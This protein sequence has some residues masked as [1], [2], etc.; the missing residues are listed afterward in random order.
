MR[1]VLACAGLA[2]SCG[3]RDT[4]S[5]HPPEVVVPAAV[6]TLGARADAPCTHAP[7]PPRTVALGALAVDA[8][9][10]TQASWAALSA[11]P[12][13]PS[14][15]PR[16]PTCPVDILT[17]AEARQYCAE[18]ARA[19]GHAPCEATADCGGWRLPTGDEWEALARAGTETGTWAGEVSA[20][21]THDPL[22][23]TIGWTK[24]TSGG[25]P[26]PVGGLLASG[27]GLY[28]VVGNL[29]EWTAEPAGAGPSGARALRGGSWYHNVERARAEA[30][31]WAP[32]AQR[33][34][35]ADV[36]CVRRL[37]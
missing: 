11:L 35:W 8:T 5:P 12:P 10:A 28:D 34:S 33:L 22:V 29:A 15:G 4:S 16:C 3:A 30:V 31:L 14:F 2:F 27:W 24:T 25:R 17:H 36:R 6:H 9:E 18:R 23:A 19:D 13:D 7:A 20:C 37:P 21:M 26:A 1:L 32:P